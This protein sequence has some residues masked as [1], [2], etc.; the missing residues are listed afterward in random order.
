MKID[1]RHLEILAAIVDGGGLTE[2]AS[3]LGKSQPSVSRSLTMLEQRLGVKLF[4]PNRRPL[5]PTEFCLSLAAEG[6]RILKAGQTAGQLANRFRSGQAGAVRIAGT[7]VF[8]DGVV[9]PRIAAF[10]SGHPDIR[11]DQSYGYVPEVIEGLTKGTIDLGILPIRAEEIPD[12][13]VFT[14]ILKGRNVI[15][16]RVGHPLNASCLLY[17]SPSPRDATLSRMPS[18]A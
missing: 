16:C 8:M 3:A 4:E 5:Q 1:P 15:A 10:Q 2:G 12:H 18:S 14:E 7:P 9:S 17:T 11:I 13:L 6:R